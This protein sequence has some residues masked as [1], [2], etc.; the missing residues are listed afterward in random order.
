MLAQAAFGYFLWGGVEPW[1][2]ALEPADLRLLAG[3]RFLAAAT[4]FASEELKRIAHVL[5]PIGAFAETSGTFVNCEGRWQSWAGAIKPP[6]EARP[7]WKVLRVLANQLGL[8]GF[9]YLSSEDVREELRARCAASVPASAAGASA[10]LA[11]SRSAEP[12]G[13]R[14]PMYRV[15]ALV[16]RAPALQAVRNA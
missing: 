9:E 7:G 6:G 13:Y 12:A 11:P 16:R 1:V 8:P 2:D 4:P 14:M 5:L 15:D 10:H 3:A